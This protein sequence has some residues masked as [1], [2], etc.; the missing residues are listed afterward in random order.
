MWYCF[1]QLQFFSLNSAVLIIIHYSFQISFISFRRFLREIHKS[2]VNSDTRI[3]YTEKCSTLVP[4][5]SLLFTVPC[6]EYFGI[7]Y[8]RSPELNFLPTMVIAAHKIMPGEK[9]YKRSLTYDYFSIVAFLF[10]CIFRILLR[11]FFVWYLRR[12]NT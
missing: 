3:R 1:Q 11:F 12:D 2:V 4:A 9:Y 10:F 7:H 6:Q 5:I 8:F